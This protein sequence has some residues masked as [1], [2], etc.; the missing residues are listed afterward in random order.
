[1][2]K[3]DLVILSRVLGNIGGVLAFAYAIS[4]MVEGLNGDRFAALSAVGGPPLA[5]VGAAAAA[6]R[7]VLDLLPLLVLIGTIL[8]L[9]ALQNSREMTI[10][11][12]S[13]SSIWRAMSAPLVAML[14]LGLAVGLGVDGGVTLLTRSLA[15]SALQGNSGE[16]RPIW[17]E[18]R[19]TGPNYRMVANFVDP[20]G[21]QLR[22]VTIFM[23]DPPRLRIEAPVVQLADRHWVVPTAQILRSNQSPQL[24]TDYRLQ[25]SSTLSDLRAKL[26]APNDQTAFEL[27]NVLSGRLTDPTERPQALTRFLKLVFLPVTLAGAMVLAFAF[28]ASYQRTSRYGRTVLS[29][30]MLGF[31][32]YVVAEMASRAAYV[33][34]LPPPIAALGPSLLVLVVGATVLLYREDGRA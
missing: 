27:G 15:P 10:V 28:T 33:G 1:M 25:S 21:A 24:V 20:S 3:I 22:D 2:K 32:F 13:G 30:I 18:E 14:V 12:A 29:G 9:L 16:S 8:G 31:V 34:V 11:K 4:C 19:G 17:L 26:T 7:G 5:I 23:L 6:A